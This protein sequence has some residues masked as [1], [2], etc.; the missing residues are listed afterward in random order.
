[1]E[2]QI[3]IYAWNRTSPHHARAKEWA[4]NIF[5]S[6]SLIGIP[7]VS[8]WAFIRLT[9]NQRLFANPLDS[10]RAFKIV[11]QWVDSPNVTIPQP[12]PRHAEILELL[13]T[14][15]QAA[16]ALVCDAVLASLAI[17][18]AA[19]LA[20]TDQDFSRF[21]GLSWINPLAGKRSGI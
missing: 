5:T 1:M 15:D 9:T 14:R 6:E 3:L 13:V 10:E 19:T 11:A 20:S 8:I 17:E 4:E 18:H 21:S 2:V 16:C 12:G 7:W